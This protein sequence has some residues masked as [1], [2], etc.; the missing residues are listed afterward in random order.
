VAH[1][2]QEVVAQTVDGDYGIVHLSSRF[3]RE[4]VLGSLQIGRILFIRIGD[5]LG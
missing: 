2:F 3:S 1:S 4:K 5:N